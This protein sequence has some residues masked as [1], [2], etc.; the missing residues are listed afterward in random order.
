MLII[1]HVSSDDESEY[2]PK[3]FDLVL[4]NARRLLAGETLLN[5]I[6]R[7]ADY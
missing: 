5:L 7:D 3:T 4:E 6:D 1:P 2:L